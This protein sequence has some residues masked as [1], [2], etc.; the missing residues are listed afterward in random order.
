[1]RALRQLA[2]ALALAGITLAGAAETPPSDTATPAALA[3]LGLALLRQG[4]PGNAVISPMAAATALGLAHAGLTGPAEAEIEALFGPW[5]HGPHGLRQ[6]LPALLQQLDGGTDS[7][8]VMASR[9]WI[10]RRSA[11]AVPAAFKRRLATRYKADAAPLD[12]ADAEAARSQINGWTAEHTAGRIP[13]LLPAG[14][15]SPATRLTLTTALHFRSPWERPF[16]PALTEPR[17]FATAT[18]SKPVP[19]LVDE[20]GVLQSE[21]DGTRVLSLPF[22]GAAYTLLVAVPAEGRSLDDL[23]QAATSG[24]L[25]DWQA[26]LKPLKC[27]LALPRFSIAPR[28][29]SLKPALESLGMKTAF[30]DAA[31]LRPML[32]KAAHRVH[33][34]DVMHAAGITIDETG[35]EAVAAAAATVV[36]KAFAMPVPDCA[37]QR[38]FLFA[39]L[40]KPSGTPLFV[41]RVDD[42]T[43]Q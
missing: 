41:G 28:A 19:M 24:G 6:R 32:G 43:L 18:G 5:A 1:M 9:V 7:P 27:K 3:D 39:V 11:A 8:F 33:L 30:T 31:D 25:A 29:A 2:G 40:H 16:D 36:A 20:R 34:G 13:E 10:D 4:A 22:A 38:P 12:F 14:S 17:P 26:A 35:G 23:A 15:V 42:P 37:V 21:S